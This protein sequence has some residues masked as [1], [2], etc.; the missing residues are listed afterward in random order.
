M[1]PLAR[2][3]CLFIFITLS[4]SVGC[5]TAS[6]SAVKAAYWPS[7]SSSPPSAIDTSLF[8]HIYYAFLMPNNVTYNLEISNS[9][10]LILSNF[11]TTLHHKK[12]PVKALFSIGGGGS[13]SSVFARMVSSPVSRK[14]FINSALEVARN[15]GFDGMDLDWEFPENPKQMLDLSILFNEWREAIKAE[16]KATHRA[17]LLLTAAVYYSVDFLIFGGRRSYPVQSINRNL[18]WI[19][20]MCFD[21]HGSWN[22]S[23]TGAHAALYDPNSNISTSYGLTS[24]V[25][26]GVYPEKVVMGLPLYGRT[27]K[28]K[29]PNQHKIGSDA[30][31]LGPGDDGVL[32]FAQVENFNRRTNAT[33]A[34]DPVYVAAYSFVG[35][36]WIGYDDVRSTT[37]KVKYAL[38][39][40]L[41]GYFFWAVSYDSEWKVSSAASRAWTP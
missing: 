40:G 1:A 27:W 32:T 37:I 13:D 41:R 5:F 2:S 24:W 30:V 4:F 20:A 15:L 22:T 26:A 23:K 29:D 25:K 16:A 18:D 3:E 8:T 9:K 17:P 19:N 21:F 11:T 33:V 10:A 28:L 35:T 12:P 6:A 31:G 36:S 39:H 38:G 34:Y 14:A 7:G